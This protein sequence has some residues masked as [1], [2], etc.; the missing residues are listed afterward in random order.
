MFRK[1][2]VIGAAIAALCTNANARNI[3]SIVSL[4]GTCK[5]LVI[6]TKTDASRRCVGKLMN[7][8]YDD[9]RSGFLFVARDIAIVTFSGMG[10]AQVKVNQDEVIQPVDAVIFTLI[11]T[12]T[13][14]NEVS[15]VGSCRFTNPEQGR[16]SIV[17]C[18]ATTENGQFVADFVSDGRPPS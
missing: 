8:T 5:K 17:N 15:A 12:G 1:I 13:G 9:G 4:T 14:P 2:L 7:V 6:A 16:H 18:K 11:G 10:S 3:T